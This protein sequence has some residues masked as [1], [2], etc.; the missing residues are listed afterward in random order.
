MGIEEDEEWVDAATLDAGEHAD[1]DAAVPGEDAGS[2]APVRD[3][4]G[5]YP[6]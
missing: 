2:V 3:L 6:V 4:I 1:D 5:E